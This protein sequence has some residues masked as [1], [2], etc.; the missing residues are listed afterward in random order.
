M[1]TPISYFGG[2]VLL[3]PKIISYFPKHKNYIEVFGGSGAVLFRKS[4]VN[5]E[6]YNDIDSNL[7][8]FYRVLR[9]KDKFKEFSRLAELTLYSREEFYTVRDNLHIGDDITR[10]WKFYIVVRMAFSGNIKEDGKMSWKFSVNKSVNAN[11]FAHSVELLPQFHK[12]LKGVQIE[13]LDWRRC[14]ETYDRPGT[15]I[16]LDPPYTKN[17]RSSGEYANEIDDAD[18]EDLVA[19][20]LRCKSHFFVSGYDNSIYERLVENG[21]KKVSL[22]ERTCSSTGRTR[23]TGLQGN[24]ACKDEKRE[25]ILWISPSVYKTSIAGYGLFEKSNT[26]E[27]N[28]K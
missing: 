22:G 4:P 11:A 8:N 19:I 27:E 15:V 6:V 1:Q 14:I 16:Y 28:I 9:D 12:R 25:E 24:N 7:V 3:A 21:Y 5:L 17:E 23:L 18:H 13:N 26:K 10:A 20:I 2:K